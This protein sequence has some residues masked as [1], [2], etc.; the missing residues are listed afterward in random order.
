MAATSLLFHMSA[1]RR[2]VGTVQSGGPLRKH[3]ISSSDLEAY[4]TLLNARFRHSRRKVKDSHWL[5]LP[6]L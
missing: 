2:E 6:P 3:A 4:S 5:L 1:E